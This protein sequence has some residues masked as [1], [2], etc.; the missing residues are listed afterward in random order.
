MAGS[1]QGPATRQAVTVSGNAPLTLVPGE[2][3]GPRWAFGR[4]VAYVDL[5]PEQKECRLH[6]LLGKLG[7]PS[8]CPPRPSLL[9]TSSVVRRGSPLPPLPTPRPE[10]QPWGPRAQTS[11]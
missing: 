2:K 5:A 7:P 1:D 3:G 6:G 11:L 4:K 8:L 10:A 9:P